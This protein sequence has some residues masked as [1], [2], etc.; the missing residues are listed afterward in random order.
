MLSRMSDNFKIFYFTKIISF[1]L[2][3]N[4][5]RKYNSKVIALHSIW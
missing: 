1:T 2:S 5:F 3:I 4:I